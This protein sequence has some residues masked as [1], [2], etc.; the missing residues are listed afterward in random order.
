MFSPALKTKKTSPAM[1]PATAGTTFFRKAGDESFFGARESQAFFKA[2]IQP[3]LTV[4][5]PEDSQ[6]KEA[7][8]VAENVMRTPDT[9]PASTA[10]DAKEE[11]LSLKEE[12][13]V[14]EKELPVIQRK[15]NS[16]EEMQANLPGTDAVSLYHSDVLRQ[17]G[18]GPPAASIPF[19]QTLAS[20]KGGGS[21]LPGNTRQFMES[22][23]NADF[24]GVRVHTDT[25]SALLNSS[26]QAKAFAHGND[27]YFN[28]GQF[29]P[30][31]LEGGHLLAHELTH[32][33]QQGAFKNAS[34]LNKSSGQVAENNQIH[35]DTSIHRLN[36]DAVIA[37]DTK[38]NTV[39]A[40]T[41]LSNY[42]I[43]KNGLL[44]KSAL[45]VDKE[46]PLKNDFGKTQ[47]VIPGKLNDE[48]ADKNEVRPQDA[49]KSLLLHQQAMPPAA[50]ND[51]LPPHK[52]TIKDPSVK[53]QKNV[54]E[55]I[56]S[57]EK[58]NQNKSPPVAD[59]VIPSVAAQ[60][61]VPADTSTAQA[62]NFQTNHTSNAGVAEHTAPEPIATGLS[63]ESNKPEPVA[64]QVKPSSA[65]ETEK[66]SHP[67]DAADNGSFEWASVFE[68]HEQKFKKTSAEKK[69]SIVTDS[70]S[71]K[72][73]LIQSVDL[74][75]HQV[76]SN[77]DQAE[78]SVH[79]SASES[80]TSVSGDRDAH[81]AAVESQSQGEIARLDA[82]VKEQ[83]AAMQQK[84]AQKAQ[85]AQ[86]NTSGEATRAGEGSAQK[87]A[88]VQRLTPTFS[89]GSIPGIGTLIQKASQLINSAVA[90]IQQ[91]G[92]EM[93]RLVISAGQ[94][95]AQALL[96]V[97]RMIATKFNEVLAE[98]RKQIMLIRDKVISAFR[99]IINRVFTAIDQ[100]KNSILSRLR[101]GRDTTSS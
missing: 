43:G 5:I 96:S 79:Q 84:S 56:S 37:N 10:A 3:K 100:A 26:I 48:P 97:G 19:E 38:E 72:Q 85:T 86:A 90:K 57:P 91:A 89:L 28:S 36:D 93:A 62:H 34:N 58:N 61:P 21:A 50:V 52:S 55:E 7:D 92:Q 16:G 2:P 24:S 53:S 39:N 81:L 60:N 30:D 76:N 71:Q 70:E 46:N 42:S 51:T 18:R 9:I 87:A 12:A 15:R 32:T 22:R 69:E 29:S 64:P 25:T 4:R 23:F 13:V 49:S 95:I 80:K 68:A 82:T 8:A 1:H 78:Q 67:K 99:D 74:Q 20:S 44:R 73:H 31:S 101:E 41:T 47:P 17:S 88:Q 6:E 63:H 83:Q 77:Y 35:P 54:Q 14:E 11:K 94:W 40:K 98:G 27:I 75:T 45:D 33:I 65:G 59:T 66:A